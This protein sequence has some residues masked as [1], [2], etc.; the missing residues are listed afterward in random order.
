M[1]YTFTLYYGNGFIDYFVMN[2]E[3]DFPI[4]LVFT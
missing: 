3:F 1:L 4:F 2:Y